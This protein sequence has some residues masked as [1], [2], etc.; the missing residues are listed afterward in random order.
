M[1]KRLAAVVIVLALAVGVFIGREFAP[2]RPAAAKGS[3][4]ARYEFL[5]LDDGEGICRADQQTG[6]VTIFA[7]DEGKLK[8]IKVLGPAAA[9]GSAG[10]RYEFLIFSEGIW[11]ADQQTG[12]VTTLA[13][14]EGK[15]TVLRSTS[16]HLYEVH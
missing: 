12:E 10:A 5:P 6:E 3:G 7:P 13:R 2:M 4:G 16:A 15:F 9:K 8:A 11:R 14:Y 1:N